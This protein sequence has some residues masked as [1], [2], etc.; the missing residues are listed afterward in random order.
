M[1]I[2]VIGSG[3]GGQAIA[4]YLAIC[5][6]LVTLYGRSAEVIDSI[7]T[8]GGIKLEG[9]INGYGKLSLV[10]TSLPKAIHGANIIMIVTTANAHGTLAEEMAPYLE[11]GQIITLNPGRTGGALEF[12][13][14]LKRKS[15]RKRIYIAEAQTLVYACRVKAPGIV[16]VIG[17]KDKVLLATL[18]ASDIDHVINSLQELYPC[19]I[20]AENVLRT[21]FENIG[22][23]FHPSIVLF[24]AATIERGVSFYFYRE[25]TPHIASFI[26]AIDV[27][28]LAVAQAY[29]INIISAKDWVSYAYKDIKGNTLCERLISNPA[30]HE[31]L[32]PNTIFCR[33]LYEDI[34]TGFV[35]IAALGEIVN[36]KTPLIN[37]LITICSELLG[38]DL[39]NDGRTL[40]KMGLAGCNNAGDVLKLIK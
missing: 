19:F 35:P 29:G 34:P 40:A 37:A 27:E 24:N 16:Q 12:H 18:P 33:Q 28:R 25:M 5:G 20:P 15:F 26:E 1:K 9:C 30:Y 31:I 23:I 17:I 32:A 7:K 3:N 11:D 13:G 21:S 2:A 36:V 6:H 4:G 10:T 38:T 8:R 14:A 39:Y 22:A